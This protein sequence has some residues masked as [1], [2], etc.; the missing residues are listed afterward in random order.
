M[1]AHGV[2]AGPGTTGVRAA[3]DFAATLGA[4]I[5]RRSDFLADSTWIGM[6]GSI[7]YALDAHAAGPAM[8]LDLAVPLLTR[9]SK[10]SGETL[11]SIAD[12]ARDELWH[13]LAEQLAAHPRDPI[14]LRPG[15]EMDGNWYPWSTCLAGGYDAYAAAYRRLWS[16]IATTPGT[17]HVTFTWCVT[18]GRRSVSPT[19]ELAY[20]GDRYVDT[21]GV[22]FYDYSWLY[23]RDGQGKAVRDR[24]WGL[25]T[26]GAYSLPWWADFARAHRK[27]LALP[28]WGIGTKAD[29][30]AGGDN[31]DF[32]HRVLD[33]CAAGGIA[34][35]SYFEAQGNGVDHRIATPTTAFPAAA[36]AYRG[37]MSAWSG[38]PVATFGGGA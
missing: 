7:P 16:I 6:E 15:H 28:E 8:T 1:T 10:A 33:A 20:P 26:T 34:S 38:A 4:P 13:H 9:E 35:A 11:A 18:N 29:G 21:I 17:Q 12:G 27:P 36:G 30:T 37:R 22:D 19:P 5:T 3:Q 14:A 24:A 31:A 23:A 2:Y 25:L 32:V